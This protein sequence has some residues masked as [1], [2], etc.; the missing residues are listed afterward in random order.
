MAFDNSNRLY[1]VWSAYAPALSLCLSRAHMGECMHACVCYVVW[2]HNGGAFGRMPMLDSVSLT[3]LAPRIKGQH[4]RHATPHTHKHG[5]THH[6]ATRRV[7]NAPAPRMACAHVTHPLR[8]C[9]FV[10]H[11]RT[12]TCGITDAHATRPPRTG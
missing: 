10:P 3:I 4:V 7:Q 8:I 9:T 1:A 2:W 11:V 6:T 5:R 12:C